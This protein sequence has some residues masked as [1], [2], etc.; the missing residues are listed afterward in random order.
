MGG[1]RG[2]VVEVEKTRP[3]PAGDWVRALSPGPWRAL[4][5]K[6]QCHGSACPAAAL[7]SI[8]GALCA[9]LQAPALHRPWE[10][11]TAPNPGS[12]DVFISSILIISVP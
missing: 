8:S 6:T 7:G 11:H 12:C 1:K 9:W 10:T 4:V 5:A 2:P 3:P